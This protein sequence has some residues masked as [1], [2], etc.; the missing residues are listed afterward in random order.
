MKNYKRRILDTLL[1]KKLQT[2]GAVT[3]SENG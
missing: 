1:E 3:F 2:K